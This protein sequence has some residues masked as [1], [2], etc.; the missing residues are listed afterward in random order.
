MRQHKEDITK[1]NL[2]DTLNQKLSWTFLDGS[3]RTAVLLKTVAIGKGEYLPGWKWSQH[4]GAITGKKS[5][6]H[7]GYI[8][9]GEMMVKGPDGKEMKVGPGE[10][11]EAAPDSDAW[12]IGKSPCIALDVTILPKK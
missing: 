3:K 7:I 8:L 1:G 10:A 6:G 9:S 5:E 4:V 2:F 11:F 12:V